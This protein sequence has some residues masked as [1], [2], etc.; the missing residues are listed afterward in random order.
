M[1]GLV[2][3][4]VFGSYP[5]EELLATPDGIKDIVYRFAK[6]QFVAHAKVEIDGVLVLRLKHSWRLFLGNEDILVQNSQTK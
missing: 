5:A 4:T 1:R 3:E 6:G 2:L